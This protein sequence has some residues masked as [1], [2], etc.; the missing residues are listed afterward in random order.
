MNPQD[1]Y[2]PA[3]QPT[4]PPAAPAPDTYPQA[5]QPGYTTPQPPM[6]QQVAPSQPAQPESQPVDYPRPMP[7]GAAAHQPQQQPQTAYNADYLNQI[8]PKTTVKTNRFAVFGLI[9]AVLLLVIAAVVIFANAGPPDFSTQAKAIQSRLTTLQTVADSQ[10]PNLKENAISE[11]NS[12]L[13]SA[14]TSTSTDL[15]TLMK[16]K[17]I[18]AS[19][20]ASK[21]VSKTEKAY[22][23]A[24][25]KKLDDSYQRGT[26]DRTYTTQMTYEL[27]V[28]KNK[29]IRMKNTANSKSVTNFVDAANANIDAILKTYSAFSATK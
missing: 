8:A 9:G 15:A 20:D 29:L 18:K 27:T 26:L 1:P 28:L 10:Q 5:A 3:Q 25:K 2:P 12:S 7:L 22:A 19:S 17:G 16:T 24:L 11:A 14:L 23:D 6:P 21:N 13:S 4:T